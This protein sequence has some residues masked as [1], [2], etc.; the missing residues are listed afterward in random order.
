[1]QH[2]KAK[3]Y[4]GAP[5]NYFQR[6]LMDAVR[7]FEHH[8]LTPLLLGQPASHNMQPLNASQVRQSNFLYPDYL[9]FMDMHGDT[10]EASQSSTDWKAGNMTLPDSADQEHELD[11]R[12]RKPAR[13]LDI[14]SEAIDKTQRENQQLAESLAGMHHHPRAGQDSALPGHQGNKMT[15]LEWLE[16]AQSHFP[17]IMSGDDIE[18]RDYR[19]DSAL[20]SPS[21]IAASSEI[22]VKEDS[23]IDKPKLNNTR[24]NRFTLPIL[25]QQSHQENI[26]NSNQGIG[27]RVER[28]DAENGTAQQS[29]HIDIQRPVNKSV[30][31]RHSAI[32]SVR[33]DDFSNTVVPKLQ[34]QSE[35]RKTATSAS[36]RGEK[37]SRDSVSN[38][39]NS[40][41]RESAR[42][43]DASAPAIEPAKTNRTLNGKIDNQ[44]AVQL[45]R[46]EKL[47]QALKV[48]AINTHHI[49][50]DQSPSERPEF[51]ATEQPVAS[52]KVAEYKPQQ[53][54]VINSSTPGPGGR[55]AFLERRYL[56]RMGPRGYK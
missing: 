34:I 27:G 53:V 51:T 15:V 50:H 37:R 17:D 4:D 10:S 54:F 52:S 43:G 38:S 31:A 29:T 42:L 2:V 44:P 20:T 6:V 11:G 39:G 16:R 25:H 24:E 7:P 35:H 47:R 18:R 26:N 14:P 49:A 19:P 23:S 36:W 30:E 8:P 9:S 12:R 3:S 33:G 5:Y 1:M 46:I 48:Q 45:A 21:D 41:L 40:N 32:I 13:A 28:Q 56:G 22:G 55:P